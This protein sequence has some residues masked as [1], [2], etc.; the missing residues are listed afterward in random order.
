MADQRIFNEAVF[1]ASV[2]R[3]DV[4]A[5]RASAERVLAGVGVVLRM[6]DTARAEVERLTAAATYLHGPEECLE[7]ECEEYFDAAGDERPGVEYCSH[8]KAKRL[9]VDEHLAVLAE[10]DEMAARLDAQ[11]VEHRETGQARA[12]EVERLRAALDATEVD[13]RQ[14]RTVHAQTLDERD[15]AR[16]EVEQIRAELANAREQAAADVE[17]HAQKLMD[18]AIEQVT[19]DDSDGFSAVLRAAAIGSAAK[20]LRG[21]AGT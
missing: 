14:E 13:L 3:W 12:A 9:T 7:R 2:T 6:L 15:A 19:K 8:L 18:A 5:D 21:E 16:A 17:A 20:Y 4:N 1:R 10:R 11:A